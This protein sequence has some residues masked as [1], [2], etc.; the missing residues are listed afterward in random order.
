MIEAVTD[1]VFAPVI[2]WPALL[3][4]AAVAAILFLWGVF[5]R[6]AARGSAPSPYPPC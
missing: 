5:R 1:L 2:P 6:R 4:L 3:A